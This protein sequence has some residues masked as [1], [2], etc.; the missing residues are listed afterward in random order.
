VIELN[1]EQMAAY[2]RY[3]KAADNVGLGKR[4]KGEWVPFS[5]V[6]GSLKPDGTATPL[7][8]PN[9]LWLEYK[10]AVEAWLKVEPR[11][12]HEERLRSTRGDYDHED[13]WDEPEAKVK[14]TFTLIKEGN[15]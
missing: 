10:A 5:D 12:R 7:F 9:E 6:L 8:V 3:K 15:T 2:Q 1:E 14:D 13:S 11:F 4:I